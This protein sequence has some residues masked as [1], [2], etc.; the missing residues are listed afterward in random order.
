[1]DDS[2]GS[3][4]QNRAMRRALAMFSLA[5]SLALPGSARPARQPTAAERAEAAMIKRF[6]PLAIEDALIDQQARITAAVAALPAPG[7]VPEMPVLAIGGEGYLALFDREA[8]RAAKVLAAR[9]GGPALV[10]SNTPEQVFSGLLASRRTMALAVAAL[11]RRARPGDTLV[12][13]LTSH[14]GPDGSIA[15]DAPYIDFAPMTAVDLAK[16]MDA[17]GFRRRVVIVSACYGASWIPALAS[18]TTIVVAAAA[19]DRTS[20]GC[21]DSRD[22]TLFGEALIGALGTP[23][24][25]LATAFAAAKARIAAQERAMKITPSLPEARVGAGM[26]AVWTGPG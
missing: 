19:A 14:G 18:P 5:L 23:G 22:L 8:R 11:G 2:D 7:S 25:S 1:M 16:A 4:R 10:L 12:V 13:Y 15:M 6:E 17:A 24:V 3:V 20:F 9:G 21:D 26:Q